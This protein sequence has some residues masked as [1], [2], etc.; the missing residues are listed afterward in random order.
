MHKKGINLSFNG[1]IRKYATYILLITFGV[2]IALVFNGIFFSTQYVFHGA[3]GTNIASNSNSNS[4][5]N[6][7]TVHHNHVK[8]WM[9]NPYSIYSMGI[10]IDT[11]YMYTNIMSI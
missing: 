5:V 4:N 3:I 1:K 2:I 6:T 7:N 10:G 11:M 8:N 9:Q